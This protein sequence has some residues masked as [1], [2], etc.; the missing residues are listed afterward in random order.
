M[1]GL[2]AVISNMKTL[3]GIMIRNL[4]KIYWLAD[5]ISMFCCS[6]WYILYNFRTP[7]KM[8]YFNIL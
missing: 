5:D 2:R 1:L 8:I 6:Y 7:S 4:A 3:R